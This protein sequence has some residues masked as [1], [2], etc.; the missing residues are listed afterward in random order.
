MKLLAIA[1]HR[2]FLADL[3]A[4]LLARAGDDPAALSRMLVLL[5]T[6]RAARALGEAFLRQS[7]GRALL[8][9]RMIPIAAAE[10]DDLVLAGGLDLPPAVEPARRQGVLAR[11]ILAMNGA[12]GAPTRPDQAWRLAADLAAL[13]DELAREEVPAEAL[14]KIVPEALAHH[15]QQT[16]QFLRIV[17]ESW[18]A[19]L[20]EAG[21][22]DPA[23]RLVGL[24]D[25]RARAWQAAPPAHPVIAAGFAN[26]IPAVGRLLR[27]VARLD[28]GMVVLAGLD[29]AMDAAAFDAAAA[30]PTHP[31]AGQ[32]RLLHALDARRED[33]ADWP[34]EAAGPAT[35]DARPALLSMALLPADAMAAW[36]VRA[37]DR[38]RAAAEGLYL[39]DAPEPNTAARGIALALR[40]AIETRG[41]T[42]AL[43]TPDRALAL[44]VSAELA[45]LGIVADDSAGEPLGATPPG[46]FLRLLAAAP[47]QDFAPVPLL[48]LL[49][50]PL[51]AA[52][53]APEALRREVR[54]LEKA[55]LRGIR[56]PPGIAALR[57][58]APRSRVPDLLEAALGSFAR[59]DPMPPALRLEAQL[60]AAERLAAA[61]DAPGPLRLWAGEEGEALAAHLNA[62]SAAFETLPPCDAEAYAALFDATLEGAVARG[63][64]VLR[65]R[66]EGTSEHPRVAIWGLTEARLQR[67]DT[68]VLAGLEEARWPGAADPGPW[69]SRAMRAQAGL[70]APEQSIGTAA[71]DFALLAAAAPE[72]L[73][74]RTAR[75]EGAPTVPSR[76][77]TRLDAFLRGQSG[78]GLP[79]ASDLLGWATRL[80]DPDGPPVPVAPPAPCPAT[81]RPAVLTQGDV[82]A[83]MRDPYEV[84]A[85]RVLRLR[86]LD[87]LD[88]ERGA[89]EFGTLVHEAMARLVAG[90]GAAQ[91]AEDALAS[92]SLPR[93]LVAFW[94][95]RLH[96]VA[97]W[98]EEEIA[99]RR[100]D[101]MSAHWAEVEGI[102]TF[103]PAQVRARADRIEAHPDGLALVDFKTG[104]APSGREVE[105]G[106]SP[107][108]VV[109][110]LIA[111]AGGF[112]AVPA[113]AVGRLEYWRASGGAE[114]GSVRRVL[115]QDLRA[116]L[117]TARPRLEALLARF[118]DPATPYLA[119][120]HPDAAPR[121][122]DYEHL[123]RV[124]EWGG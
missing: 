43:V 2:P 114:P 92:L 45:R 103:G 8:L 110:A 56:P 33:V 80:D 38:W 60:V 100:A 9:P 89:R 99:R 48:A 53:I 64:R 50:H 113:G 39:L 69:L 94:R 58:A 124:Q 10:A 29:R 17:T 78:E 88:Q 121:H 11:L 91:A 79:P 37:P 106:R 23:A 95:P 46:A 65:G 57:D 72:V 97:Q 74:V 25:A 85:K 24:L 117:D 66:P 71:A 44:R 61:P 73:L 116:H 49:K 21:L 82:E 63:R 30:E 81:G 3:A 101:G 12:G 90:A 77:L 22:A 26:P 7:A 59:P 119:R 109:E 105:A 62:V 70:P 120:P 86:P 54:A 51:A 16:L 47:A 13:F 28:Q 20:A 35:P 5:P 118:A 42:A 104:A 68:L 83:L 41:R 40:A 115:G 122:S 76:W 108:L 18:P 14:A 6:R 1:A 31:Q 34:H 75:V 107:Q 112:P 27:T 96:R 123:A 84:Y 87:P 111:E 4:G 98:A 93:A 52:G 67:A 55:A 32:A 19:W 36:T 15:W 102:A